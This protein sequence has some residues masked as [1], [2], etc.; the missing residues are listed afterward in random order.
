M[1]SNRTLRQAVIAAL[2]SAAFLFQGTWAL[3]G[4]TGN[5]AGTIRDSSGA[6][7]AGVQVQAVSP[8][9]SRTATTD[10]GGRFI[11]LALAPDTYTLNLS[12]EGFES[13][14]YPGNVVFADQNQQVSYTMQR[15]LR[16]IAHVTAQSAGALVKSGVGSDLYSVNAT[17]AQAARAL[18][19]GGNLNN[20]YSAMASVPGIQTPTGGIGWTFNGAYVRGANYYQTAFEYDGIPVNRA[21]DNYNSSTESTL[22]LQELQVYTG[23]G[24]SSVA[25]AGT[26]GFINQVIKTGTFP[27]YASANLGVGST[28][29]YHQAQV[30]AGGSTPDRTFSY[31]V[32]LL[33]YNQDYRL[34]NNING[35]NLMAPGGIYSGNTLGYG[36]G[37]GEFS[38]QILN[39][40]P[41]CFAT[42]IGS[43]QGVK[44]M[45]SLSGAPWQTPPAQGCWQFYSGLGGYPS[46]VSDRESVVNLHVGIPKRN[47]LRDDIQLLFSASALNNYAYQ[48]LNDL[49]PGNNQLVYALNNTV[50]RPPSCSPQEIAPGLTA[51]ACSSLGQIV[52]LAPL[53]IICG[54]TPATDPFLG[55]ASTY[56]GYGDGIAY[57][58]P[59]GTPIARSATSV[60]VPGIY[61]E[62]GTPPHDFDG[63]LPLNDSSI[64][65]VQNDVA[66][67]KVQY[68][69]ALSQSAYLRAYGYSFYSNWFNTFPSYGATDGYAPSLYAAD[70]ELNAHTVGAALDYQDQLNDQ[71][72]LGVNA[73][74][75]TSNT[76]RW[77]NSSAYAGETQPIGY[78]SLKNGKYTCY[79]PTTGTT[80]PCIAN[81]YYD[82]ASK[83]SIATPAWIATAN[84]GPDGFAAAGTPAAVAGAT[85]DSLWT[86]NA[87][88]SLN[89]VG[90]RFTNAS[91]SDQFRPSDKLLFNAAIRFDNFEYVLPD[92]NTPDTAFYAA[93]LAN[94]TC[95]YKATN[96]VLT[97]PLGPG[98]FPPAPAQYVNGDCNTAATALHPSG[99]HTGWVHPNGTVQDGVQAPS[100]TAAS[101][102]SYTIS[103]W[104]PRVSATYTV[105]PDSVIRASAGRFTQPPLTASVQYL[106]STGD[107]RSVWSDT[108]DLGFYSPFHPI[109]AISAAQYDASWE[110][111]LRGTDMSFKLTP[112]Y[113]WTTGWQQQYFI[114]PGFVTQV[115]VGVARDEGAEFQ[116]NKGDFTRNGWS[117]QLGV[118]YTSAKIMF[119]NV[120][121]STGGTVING[122]T[123]LN[124]A[125]E[126][127]NQLTKAGG[128]KPC[129]QD[130]VGVACSTPNGKIAAGYDTILNPYYNLPA[131]GLLSPSGWYNPYST[132]IGPNLSD[133]ASSYIS[134]WVSSIIVN[135]RHDRLAIT[136]SIVF[137]T[138]GFYGSPLDINGVDPRTCMENSLASGI[139]KVSPKTNP[140][141][142]NYLTVTSP[143]EGP[144]TYLYIPNPE[145]GTFAYSNYENPSILV[146]NLQVSYD[147]TPQIKLSVLGANIFHT[148]FGGSSEPWTAANPPGPNICGYAAAGG[149]LN[150]SVYPSNFYNGTGINDFAANKA[151]TPAAFQQ[152]YLP[153]TGINSALGASVPPFNVYI[154]ASVRI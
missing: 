30:E 68:T 124:Q 32:G 111:H 5:L 22:G 147:V 74:Y 112:F 67:G 118:T 84:T 114:G 125:I 7:I 146:G 144:F 39:V 9:E 92:S 138:G 154:N 108:M 98:I 45:C 48:N 129:Y 21:F 12:R 89:N 85:W 66:I 11:F 51:N 140:L 13:V 14:S 126:Q 134:P 104:S 100:F 132:A 36:I 26:S 102:G 40:C 35:A 54:K 123:P 149:S 42:S 70:Y 24:P 72:L 43:G 62:P 69:Y 96:Q 6:P 44:P 56:L 28:V 64:N 37:Y 88:G 79:S 115:P 139:T 86:G 128:G 49:G 52:S 47:G 135:Y 80:L 119:Q 53:G 90:P 136:P 57:D 83:T 73:N 33:G 145:T 101:P 116:F 2:L 117:G 130:G 16:T 4:T 58:V 137:Q 19:G 63:P 103:T 10:S 143:G 71:N 93:M 107:E 59:F 55:C 23:G 142:C 17:Q 87:T 148:C 127:Y 150:S 95:V 151:R 3:A 121:L 50:Y 91:L 76:V 153:T 113:T 109:P 29:F 131:Q 94:Y 81:G 133:D 60:K 25:S 61:F 105:S 82:V 110:Q 31:Y 106:S 78:M 75:T 97:E 77:N 122:T 65:V 34:L 141:Q 41:T 38:D 46:Q 8:S 18:G 120:G 152:P 99:P 27:G 20:T 1:S 15:A